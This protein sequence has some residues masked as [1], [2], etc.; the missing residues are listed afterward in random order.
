MTNDNKKLTIGIVDD[1]F[2][3]SVLTE[4]FLTA[5]QIPYP[6]GMSTPRL[7]ALAAQSPLALP[8]NGSVVDV[9]LKIV[10]KAELATALEA[11]DIDLGIAEYYK[12]DD[13]ASLPAYEPAGTVKRL[14]RVFAAQ[15]GMTEKGENLAAMLATAEDRVNAKK[16]MDMQS[17]MSRKDVSFY[18]K[19]AM[20]LGNG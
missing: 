10:P 4:T 13:D 20:G 16:A 7:A 1:F 11:G 2:F 6:K 17:S 14:C 5:A 19:R 12:R 3:Q 9:D 18:A 8:V 15:E